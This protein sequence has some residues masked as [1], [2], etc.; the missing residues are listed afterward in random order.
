[1]HKRKRL[2]SLKYRESSFRPAKIKI[3]LHLCVVWVSV[4]GWRFSRTR[5]LESSGYWIPVFTSVTFRNDTSV[6]RQPSL[7]HRFNILPFRTKSKRAG[8]KWELNTGYDLIWFE[9][10]SNMLRQIEKLLMTIN[11]SIFLNV[12]I[13]Y[14]TQMR[15]MLFLKWERFSCGMT[16]IVS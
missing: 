14:C 2:S 1:M 8:V 12:F 4:Y 11:F 6:E 13:S 7:E 9:M 16:N 5:I 10:E 3:N 15:K